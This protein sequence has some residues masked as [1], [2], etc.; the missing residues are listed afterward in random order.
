MPCRLEA[1]SE[2]AIALIRFSAKIK[3]E[4]PDVSR[5][6]H[7]VLADRIQDQITREHALCSCGLDLDL[8]PMTLMYELDVTF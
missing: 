3:K 6:G 4:N 5:N 1:E 7:D 8:D 2:Y